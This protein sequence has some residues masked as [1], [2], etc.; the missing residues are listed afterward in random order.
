MLVNFVTVESKSLY[1]GGAF[2]VIL[3]GHYLAIS[4][5]LIDVSSHVS[6][7]NILFVPGFFCVIT[8]MLLFMP[9]CLVIIWLTNID[10]IFNLKNVKEKLS[11]AEHCIDLYQKLE[12]YLGNFQLWYL[13]VGQITWIVSFFFTISLALGNKGEWKIQNLMHAMGEILG[14]ISFPQS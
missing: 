5:M 6:L 1:L 4:P 9:K 14:E 10:E 11:W 2:V 3:S 12:N 13:A 7:I 8:S